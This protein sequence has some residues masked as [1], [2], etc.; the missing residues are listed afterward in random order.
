[1]K[2]R[3]IINKT[4][5]KNLLYHREHPEAIYVVVKRTPLDPA[6]T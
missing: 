3:V 1:V 4:L 2:N 6:S 5:E